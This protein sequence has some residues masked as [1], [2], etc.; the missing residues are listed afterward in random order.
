[1]FDPPCK[2]VDFLEPY[3]VLMPTITITRQR[4]YDRVWTETVDHVSKELGISNVGLGKLCRRHD[5][6][7]PPR[8]Y[9]AKKPAGTRCDKTLPS[10]SPRSTLDAQ[11]GEVLTP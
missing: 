5:I 9:W 6:P 2:I 7:V 4:L 10:C 1:M 3:A 11:H 8:G